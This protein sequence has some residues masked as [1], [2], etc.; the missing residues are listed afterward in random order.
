MNK[1]RLVAM[2]AICLALVLVIL[3]VTLL[4][5]IL[6]GV[7][8]LG[9]WLVCLMLTMVALVSA[10]LELKRVQ[11]RGRAEQRAL[12][13]KTLREVQHEKSARKK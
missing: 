4:E 11:A 2:I 13:E 3:A 7:A 9:Y 6:S 8:L 1:L 12:L 10:W 5:S